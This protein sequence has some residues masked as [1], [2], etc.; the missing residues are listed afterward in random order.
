MLPELACGLNEK[1]VK[2]FGVENISSNA[3]EMTVRTRDMDVLDLLDILSVMVQISNAVF[4]NRFIVSLACSF[5]DPVTY[6]ML[7]ERWYGVGE[8]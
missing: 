8:K 4:L 6:H 5:W 7:T 3:S 2:Y 1:V